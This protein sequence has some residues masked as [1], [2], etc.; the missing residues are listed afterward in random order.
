MDRR[1]VFAPVSRFLDRLDFL[2]AGAWWWHWQR[3]RAERRLD[4]VL[5]SHGEVSFESSRATDSVAQMDFGALYW[6]AAP[7]AVRRV[8]EEA[9][10]AGVPLGAL[11]LAVVNRDLQFNDNRVWVR[12]SWILRSIAVGTGFLFWFHWF[13]MIVLTLTAQG[14]W[15]LKAAVGI[16]VTVV[17]FTLYRGWSLF[18]GRPC[19]VVSRWGDHLQ[20]IADA[21]GSCRVTKG[22][23]R[24]RGR[25]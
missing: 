17:Y 22:T 25:N 19:R 7:G 8:V 10:K 5:A 18:L 16:A 14:S 13:L 1:T 11:R 6:R 15:A 2:Y 21:R 20:R 9:R 23:F 24:S 12:R 4:R 3:Y